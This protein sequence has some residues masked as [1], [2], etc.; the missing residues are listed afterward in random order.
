MNAG[1][2][3]ELLTHLASAIGALA[4]KYISEIPEK[5]KARKKED[6]LEREKKEAKEAQCAAEQKMKKAESD[7]AVIRRRSS[8]PYYFP[9]VKRMQYIFDSEAGGIII[10]STG[11]GNVLCW[12]CSEV[13]ASVKAGDTIIF[14]LEN[15]GKG[16]AWV[17]MELDGKS[18]VFARE[19]DIP[20]ADGIYFVKY[21]FET[22]IRGNRQILEVR[23]EAE[24]IVDCHRYEIFHGL[25][26][27]RR[28][29]PQ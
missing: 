15:R 24:G 11:G 28:I 8:G 22:A 25:R 29:D 12:D 2:I 10:H 16:A 17:R 9:S 20:D 5:R 7:L 27:L 18:V 19:P 14:A 21:P 1:M 13:N 4:L 26:I 23:F 3:L 6:E